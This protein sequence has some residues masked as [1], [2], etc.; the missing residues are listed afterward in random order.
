MITQKRKFLY[1]PN[2]TTSIICWSWTLIVLL[3]GVII[4]LEI[5]HFQ[6]ITLGF[7][8]AFIL[9]SWIQIHFRKLILVGDTLTLRSVLHPRGIKMNIK[10]ISN[11]QLKRFQLSFNYKNKKYTFV[12]PN[13]STIELSEALNNK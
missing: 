3:I 11:V 7:F 9:L 2:I 8:I 5:T 6:E 1:Q 13:N 4:W 10:D 12:L